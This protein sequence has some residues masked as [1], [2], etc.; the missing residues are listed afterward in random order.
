MSW[1]ISLLILLNSPIQSTL[2]NCS[3]FYAF[4]WGL[5]WGQFLAKELPG[6]TRL[7]LPVM[8]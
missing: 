5:I 8:R 6:I 2:V 1:S 7:W 4:D 3:P